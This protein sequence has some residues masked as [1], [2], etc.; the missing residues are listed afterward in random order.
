MGAEQS[1]GKWSPEEDLRLLIQDSDDQK[2]DQIILEPRH[3]NSEKVS[4]AIKQAF[5]FA[6]KPAKCICTKYT[7]N[8]NNPDEFCLRQLFPDK[9]N[10]FEVPKKQNI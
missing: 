8:N 10:Y 5:R 4:R 3:S 7:K 1:R 6:Q 2:N 9:V